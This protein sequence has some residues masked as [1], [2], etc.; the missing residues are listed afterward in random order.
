MNCL[1]GIVEAL[2]GRLVVGE[3]ILQ[4]GFVRREEVQVVRY[5]IHLED[6]YDADLCGPICVG[7]ASGVRSCW[8]FASVSA[9]LRQRICLVR[10]LAGLGG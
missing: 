7:S 8:N 6:P 5:Q 9:I 4:G 10:R 1:P 3:G 2:G